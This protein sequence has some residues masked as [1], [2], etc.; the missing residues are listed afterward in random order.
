MNEASLDKQ[1]PFLQTGCGSTKDKYLSENLN[2]EGKNLITL[3]V[4][5]EKL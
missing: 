1:V 5:M 4:Q 3:Y 2:A